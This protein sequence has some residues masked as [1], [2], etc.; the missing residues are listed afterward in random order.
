MELPRN[1]AETV[2]LS[3]CEYKEQKKQGD[4]KSMKKTSITYEFQ[5]KYFLIHNLRDDYSTNGRK[6]LK[7]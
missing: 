2:L 6:K 1:A 5:E 7:R 4:K 3:V